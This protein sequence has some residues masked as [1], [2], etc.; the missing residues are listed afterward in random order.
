MKMTLNGRP[1]TIPAPYEDDVLFSLLRDH[2]RLRGARFGCGAGTC[3]AC[4]VLIEGEPVRSCITPAKSVNGTNIVTLEGIGESEDLHPIQQAWI[5]ES[6]P[7]CGYC[8]NGQIMTAYALLTRDPEA[9]SETIS[10][11]MDQV[12][13]RCGTQQ[14]IRRAIRRAQRMMKGAS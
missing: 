1:E 3:G 11:V 8:Q 7:Q 9:D 4:T 2:F 5:A 12:L 10:E 14:R 13:C 6:V